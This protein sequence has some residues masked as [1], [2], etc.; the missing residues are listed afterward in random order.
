MTEHFLGCGEDEINQYIANPRTVRY[1]EQSKLS[2][3]LAM[4][5]GGGEERSD[6]RRG[7]GGGGRREGG[8]GSGG[9][10]GEERG[11]GGEEGNDSKPNSR[12]SGSLDCEQRDL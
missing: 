5:G 1:P 11:G 7:D 6:G 10:E 4:M 12:A 9:R 3:V 8:E 2:Q